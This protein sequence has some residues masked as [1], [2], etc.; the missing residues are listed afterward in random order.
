VVLVVLLPSDEQKHLEKPVIVYDNESRVF[1]FNSS[2]YD[3]YDPFI[4]GIRFWRAHTVGWINA[5]DESSKAWIDNF[6][7]TKLPCENS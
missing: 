1:Y 5:Y 6:K 4:I 3:N 2:N 7:L